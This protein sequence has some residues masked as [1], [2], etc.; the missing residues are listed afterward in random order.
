MIVAQ[1]TAH[2]YAHSTAESCKK[3]F[4]VDFSACVKFHIENEW[5][6]WRMCEIDIGRLAIFLQDSPSVIEA[7]HT[8]CDLGSK[9]I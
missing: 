3:K 7:R 2:A 9:V 6:I 5:K 4:N 1:C 8:Q